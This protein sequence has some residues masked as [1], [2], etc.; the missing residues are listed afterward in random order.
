MTRALVLALA[1]LAAGCVSVQPT[2]LSSPEGL[3]EVN[4]RAEGQTAIVRVQGGRGEEVRGLRVGPDTTTWMARWGGR[5]ESAPTAEVASITFR[6]SGA[7]KGLAIGVA[8]GAVLGLVA[9]AGGDGHPGFG[10]PPTGLLIAGAAAGAGLAG[11]AVGTVLTRSDVYRPAPPETAGAEPCG[12]PP[13]ACAA[14]PARTSAL[15]TPDP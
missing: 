7:V 6:R 5:P 14:P 15:P 1:L 11:M 10:T 9:S 4:A 3:A 2:P 12:G 13:L 8:T